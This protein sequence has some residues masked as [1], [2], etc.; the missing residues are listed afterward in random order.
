MSF[1]HYTKPKTFALPSEKHFTIVNMSFWIVLWI[2]IRIRSDP[3]LFGRIRTSG[4]GS[5]RLGL[6]PD[7]G[8]YKLPY[9]NHLVCVKAIKLKESLL[10]NLLVH[11]I[12]FYSMIPPKKFPEETWEKIYWI[13][14]SRIQIRS[15]IVRNI[16]SD[17]YALLINKLYCIVSMPI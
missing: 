16:A 5:G 13:F 4:T 1:C 15:K 6:D 8:P 3:D 9:L 10:F 14:Q 2:R 11:G 7:P 12:T 17:T